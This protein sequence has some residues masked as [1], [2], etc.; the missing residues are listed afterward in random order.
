[1]ELV[2]YQLHENEWFVRTAR[3]IL[4]ERGANEEVHTALNQI[5][6]NHPDVTRKL[7]ALWSLH[8]TGGTNEAMLQKLLSHENEYIRSWSIQLLLEKKMV[9]I[10]TLSALENLAVNDSS[11][12]VRLYLTAG[13]M[14]MPLGQRWK[15]LEILTGKEEDAKDHNL[16]LMLW[17]AAE[18]LAELNM[19]RLIGIAEVTKMPQFLRFTIQRIGAI[20]S[21][22]AKKALRALAQRLGHHHEYHEQV[23]LI[24][25]LTAANP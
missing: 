14:R 12:L 22:N 3:T 17:Y 6:A 13:L 15:I 2:N 9:S 8:V 25:K 4:Q 1:M 23:R 11:P 5:L 18:P 7:R 16:P 10:E 20:N 19:E 21:E 24:E